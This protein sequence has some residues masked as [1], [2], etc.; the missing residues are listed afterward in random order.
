MGKDNVKPRESQTVPQGGHRTAAEGVPCCPEAVQNES[1]IR[2]NVLKWFKRT[3]IPEN[4]FIDR[5][6]AKNC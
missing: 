2:K 5:P 3:G 4:I 6:V 1:S